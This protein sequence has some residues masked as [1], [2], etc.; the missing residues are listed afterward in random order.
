MDTGSSR[1]LNDIRCVPGHPE[2]DEYMLQLDATRKLE[3]PRLGP[4]RRTADRTLSGWAVREQAPTRHRVFVES[5]R[6]QT[7]AISNS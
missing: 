4:F 7:A 2:D 1:Q 3:V 6:T 5:H